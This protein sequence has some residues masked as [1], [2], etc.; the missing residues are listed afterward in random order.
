MYRTHWG[1]RES[2]FRSCLDPRFFFQ[3]PTHEEALARLQFLVGENR[4]L[5]LL[6]GGPGSGKSMVLE[7]LSRQLRRAGAQVANINLLGVDPHEFLWLVAAE[8]G[9]SPN[10]H[11]ELGRLWRMTSDRIAENRYQQLET[12]ILLDDA[13]ETS[14][15]VLDQV[16]RL[17]LCDT[18]PNARLTIVLAGNVSEVGRLGNR[19]LEL[20]ELRIDIE[21]WEQRDT[22]DY[23]VSSLAA[24]G[25]KAPAFHDAA[26]HRLHQLCE[27]VP[28]RV[29]QLANLAL[30]AGAGRGLSQIDADT[31]DSA[32][33]ELGVVDNTPSTRTLEVVRR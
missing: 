13:D 30:L 5:G 8:L 14:S 19:L 6:L 3:S 1:L 17:A 4:R 12:V 21:P 31:V 10:Q 15:E 32:Y 27:G 24:A 18:S 29:N 22:V 7:V 33:Q 9:A 20:A 23:L 16:A 11:E 25:R 2:P 28:R 26:M